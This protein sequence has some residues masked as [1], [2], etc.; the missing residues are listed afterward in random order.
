MQRLGKC[1]QSMGRAMVLF[2]VAGNRYLLGT[3]YKEQGDFARAKE[4]LLYALELDE[5][6]PM[7]SFRELPR[8]V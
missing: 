1:I 4:C 2:D 6:T 7:G 5:S 8:F 3:V